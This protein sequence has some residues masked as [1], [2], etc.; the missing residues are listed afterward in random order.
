MCFECGSVAIAGS[1]SSMFG[2]TTCSPAHPGAGLVTDACE[3]LPKTPASRA[4]S[5]A[6]KRAAV[7]SSSSPDPCSP[8]DSARP[9]SSPADVDEAC[10]TEAVRDEHA[11]A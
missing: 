11:T 9:G 6:S 8:G 4:A 7:P 5:N 2:L 10:C 1:Q 3:E